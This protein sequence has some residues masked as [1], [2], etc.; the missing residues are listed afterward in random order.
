MPYETSWSPEDPGQWVATVVDSVWLRE[1]YEYEKR[2]YENAYNFQGDVDEMLRDFKHYVFHFHDEFVEAISAGVWFEAAPERLSDTAPLPPHPLVALDESTVVDRF[3]GHGISCQVRRN[4]LTTAQLIT[5][6]TFC[7]QK[8]FQ[9]AAELDGRADV[10]WTVR[11]RTRLGKPFA[12]LCAYFGNVTREYDHIPTLDEVRPHVL[13]WLEEV[14]ERRRE[15][16]K[17]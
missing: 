7:S 2:H 4:P 17:Q 6:A 9:F 8:L 5:N 14:S 15:M 10:D 16:G 11:I 12:Q 3:V 1:R 13:A